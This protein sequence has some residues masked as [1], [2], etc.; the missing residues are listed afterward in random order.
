[1]LLFSTLLDINTTLDKDTFIK[2]VLEWNQGSPHENNIIKNISWNGERNVH[3][4]DENLWLDIVEYRNQNIIA[5]RYEKRDENGIVWDTDYV[6]NFNSMKMAVRLDRSYTEDALTIDQKFST[7]HFITLLINKGYIKEDGNLPVLRNPILISEKN[8]ELLT[9]IIN[10]KTH[11]RLPVVYISKTY[12]DEDPVNTKVLA[13]RLKGVAHVLVQES[14]CTN[15]KLRILCNSQNEYYGA[16]GIYYANSAIGHRRYLYRTSAGMDTYLLEK[17][18]RVVIQN[19]NAQLVGTL[20]TWQGVNNAL[21]MDR[22]LSQKEERAEAEKARREALYELLELKESL[23]KAQESMKKEALADAKLEADKILDG[24]E[25]DMQKLRN[26]I[27]RLTRENEKLVYE[28]MGL[29]LKLDSNTSVPILFM[30][31]EDDFYQGEI[32]DLVLSAVKR[33]LDATE[34]QTRRYDVLQ[35]VMQANDYQ[36]ISKQRADEA[37]R[38]LSNYDGMTPKVKKGLE[39]IGYVFDESDHQKVKYY[40]DDR[41]T[42]IYASTPGDKGRGGKNNAAI[43]VKKAF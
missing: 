17:V 19:S 20:Y 21:L 40:G 13:G 14:N 32:K 29:R 7:P 25:E 35:D 18:I 3:Y 5:V 28:N 16:I 31:N 4:G 38:L 42:V 9:D 41:Y 26:E 24:F 27:S 2:L 15:G 11:Y 6:M 30:G 12:F 37:K 36:G 1:M 43:T 8:I 39:E 22:L 33:E 10:E 34:P 23:G